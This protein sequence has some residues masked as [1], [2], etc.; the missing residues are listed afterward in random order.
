MV[1]EKFSNKNRQAYIDMSKEFFSSPAVLSPISDEN[2]NNT[3]DEI[4]KNSML[5][6]GLFIK[7]GEEIAGY[8]QISFSYNNDLGG[9]VLWVEELFIKQQFRTLGLG[10]KAMNQISTRYE[11]IKAIRLEVCDDNYNAIKL[12]EK[13]GYTKREYTQYV[14][15]F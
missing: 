4:I 13:I 6:D 9:K 2:L 10:K 15:E 8:T 5:C 11:N 1:L 14:K 12:Y 3:F 7:L